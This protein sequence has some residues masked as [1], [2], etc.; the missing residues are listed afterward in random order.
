MKAIRVHKYGD[1]SQ[2]SYEEI[3]KPTPKVGELR[4]QVEA[5]GLNFIEIYLRTGLYQGKLP[6]T[7]GDEFAGTV[8]ALGE[9]VTDFR[10]GDRVATA[11]G[12]EGYAQYS[13]AP[14]EKTI[15][16]PDGISAEQAAA[17]MLQGITAHYLAKSTYPLK[18][19]ETV[20]IHAAAGGVGQLLVQIAKMSGARVLATISSEEKAKIAKEVGADEVILYSKVDF[21][22]E[23]N[24]LTKGRGVDVVY[25]GVGK[26]TFLKGLDCLKP[27]GMMVTFGNASGAP[28]AIEPRILVR[29]GSLFLTRPS[30]GHYLQD[31]EEFLW[32]ANDLFDW[33]QAGQLNVRVDKA[34]PLEKAADAQRY[35][36]AGSTKGKVLLIP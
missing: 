21:A 28:E 26:K 19:G 4:V 33:I 32:R 15:K 34:F 16:V 3:A 12:D 2:L 11:S 23:V 6:F 7:P 18:P 10:I 31:R 25:D 8:D 5:T 24:R 9:G 30:I 36:E 27:R 35:M 22:E 20:L 1:A 29:K 14:A 17:V 13:I